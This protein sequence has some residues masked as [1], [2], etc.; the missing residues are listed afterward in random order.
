MFKPTSKIIFLLVGY[1]SSIWLI[2][3]DIKTDILPTKDSTVV[4]NT[5]W[6]ET[7]IS[8]LAYVKDF[9]FWV[10]M[11]IAIWVF[12]YIWFKLIIARWNQEEFKKAIQTFIYAIVGIAFVWLAWALVTIASSLNI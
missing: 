3:A 4:S 2:F 5:A 12:L 9:I 1:F 11:L 7:I 10:L 8:L 6:D